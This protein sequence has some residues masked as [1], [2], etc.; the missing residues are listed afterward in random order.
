M[1]EVRGSILSA[2]GYP[3][4]VQ[5]TQAFRY[6]VLC[7]SGVKCLSQHLEPLKLRMDR[8]WGVA[9]A[10][11][12]AA[13]FTVVMMTNAGFFYMSFIE[14][15]NVDRASASWPAS[16]MSVVSHSAG[17]AGSV[18]LWSGLLGA[19]WAPSIAWMSVTLGVV[20][21][22]GVGVVVVNLINVVMMYFDKYRGIAS[23]IK[24]AGYSVCS[25]LYPVILS[26]LKEAYGFRGA[27]LVY[28]ALSMNVTALTLLLK[29][30]P[31][32]SAQSTKS[33]EESPA[34]ER[35]GSPT[36]CE[37]TLRSVTSMDP[38]QLRVSAAQVPTSKGDLLLFRL[39]SSSPANTAT[40]LRD[41]AKNRKAVHAYLPE[42][43]DV[44]AGKASHSKFFPA[45]AY[46][47]PSFWTLQNVQEDHC[48]TQT[49]SFEETTTSTKTENRS[50]TC[51]T[52]DAAVSSWKEKSITDK[53]H[54][55][56]LFHQVCHLLSS[57]R[58]YVF[59]L[60]VV[61]VDYTL[62]VFPTTIVDYA[63]DKGSAR[64][65]A[66]LAVTYCAPAELLGRVA[67]PLIGDHRIV[68]RTTLVS[69][70]FFLLATTLLAL[71]ATSAF[72]SYILVCSCATMLVGCLMSLKPVVI[73]DRF[74]IEAV[75]VGYGVAGVTLLPLLLCNPTITGYFRD[76]K[77][78]YDGLYQLQAGIHGCV[79]CLF[80][81]LAVLD[82]K[83][84]R[85]LAT[86][87]VT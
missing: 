40:Y 61:A 22:A 4:M 69:A 41:R 63:L 59:V 16:V 24:F 82:Q 25:L 19:V 14:E 35:H 71:P 37:A 62:A 80:A 27:L 67:L 83:R 42:N 79:G 31:W 70:C 6:L 15:L 36:P 39:E 54:K 74:G 44:L 52:D 3:P 12:L 49:T 28:A 33:K 55:H 34:P 53:S 75:P 84:W 64:A 72:V 86:K 46:L 45:N 47:K 9:G 32:L 78:S 43:D 48:T 60:A 38:V 26:T 50:D 20:H 66:D 51:I 1:R 76:I 2:A 73:A 30:P 65:Q 10:A 8:G 56:S 17:M 81:L 13:F 87:E 5:W 11:G 58:F 57:P 23:G 77:G 18:L 29:E 7:F 21:G 85:E 68:S